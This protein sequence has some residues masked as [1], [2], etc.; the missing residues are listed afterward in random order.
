[1]EITTNSSPIRLATADQ[2]TPSV[3]RRTRSANRLRTFVT[4]LMLSLAL[5]AGAGSA[6]AAA[7]TAWPSH[8]SYVWTSGGWSN[9]RGCASTA[10]SVKFS[11]ANGS[12]VWMLCWTDGQWAYGNYGS[13]RWF[14]IWSANRTGYIHSS[15]VYNQA[16]APRC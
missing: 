14:Y 16:S 2:P 15:L 4:A 6:P 12:S 3:V 10:C 1:M 8:S 7:A 13:N 11:L 5:F 9:V